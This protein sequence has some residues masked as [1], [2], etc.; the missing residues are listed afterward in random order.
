MFYKLKSKI[1]IKKEIVALFALLLITLASTIYYNYTKNKIH[2]RYEKVIENI[3]F[4]KTINH[5][6]ES[7]EPRFKKINHK[8]KP[9]ETFDSILE[10]YDVNKK[11]ISIIKKKLSK[12]INLNK[13]TTD[14]K[15]YFTIDQTNDSIR[16]FMF[17]ISNKER[18][19]LTQD[20]EKKVLMK[21]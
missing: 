1:K 20:L 12:K 9:N 2:Q 15:I 10:S 3:Y 19:V 21:K 4:K 11:E 18:I 6:F 7:L 16:E 14:Q 13:L 8:V 5:I 17:Q